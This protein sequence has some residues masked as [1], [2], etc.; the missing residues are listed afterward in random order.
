MKRFLQ[1]LQEQARKPRYSGIVLDNDSRS[2]LLGASEVAA[3]KNPDLEHIAHH[4]TIKLGGLEG[5]EHVP[6]TDHQITATDIGY[7]GEPDNPSV[8]A[9]RVHGHPSENE[10]PHVT[11]GV[12]RRLGGE[13]VHSNRIQNWRPLSKPITLSGRI[14]EVD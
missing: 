6:G 2:R 11:I 3:F 4:M 9:V 7:L 5:T 12:N 14:T 10:T 1:Y 8:V 13:P